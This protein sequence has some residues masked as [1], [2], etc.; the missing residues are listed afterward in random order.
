MHYKTNTGSIARRDYLQGVR[1]PTWS[2]CSCIASGLM[3]LIFMPF[4]LSWIRLSLPCMCRA[5]ASYSDI[6]WIAPHF[7]IT[8]LSLKLGWNNC[9]RI[10][11]SGSRLLTDLSVN[12]LSTTCVCKNLA[13]KTSYVDES[14]FPSRVDTYVTGSLLVTLIA[15]VLFQKRVGGSYS[16]SDGFRWPHHRG[17]WPRW[18]HIMAKI[19]FVFY[20]RHTDTIIFCD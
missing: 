9:F 6:R 8:L 7:C 14:I 19:I 11:I 18:K 16:S 2:S 3:G 4:T 13:E 15:F 20:C 1:C 12:Q 5:T 10:S 17:L